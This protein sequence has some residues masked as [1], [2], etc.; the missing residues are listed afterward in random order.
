MDSKTNTKQLF[1]KYKTKGR[2]YWQK[3]QEQTSLKL[4]HAAAFGVP[5]YKLFLKQHKI[6][7]K[8]IKTFADFKKLP[9]VNK[10]NYF[11]IFPF[12]KVLWP[13]DIA[14]KGLSLCATSGST[15]NPVYFCRKDD[16]ALQYSTWIEYFVKLDKPNSKTLFIDAYGL[17]LWL[18]GMFTYDAIN[19]AGERG[20]KVT[21]IPTGI[22]KVE[23]FKSLKNLAPLFDSVVLIGY[24]PF[25]KDVVDE[26]AGQGIDFKKMNL[27]ML[28]GGETFTESFRDYL[29]DKTGIKN[30]YL[31]MGNM[32]GCSEGGIVAWET[33]VCILIKRLSVKNPEIFKKIF[34]NMSTIPTLGQ[35]N[36]RFAAFEEENNELFI[37]AGGATPLIRYQIGDRGNVLELNKVQEIFKSF[38]ISLSKEAKSKG[39]AIENLPLVAIYERN[40]FSVSFYGLQIYPQTIKLALDSKELLNHLTGKFSMAVIQDQNQNQQFEI[41]LELKPGFKG[42]AKLRELTEKIIIKNLYDNNS[43]YRELS[44]NLSIKRTKPHLVFWEYNHEKYFKSGTKQ[45]WM[46]KQAVPVKI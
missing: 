45:K 5:A 2:D 17:G 28:F 8:K 36:P 40:D 37:T 15:G 44:R 12:Q 21:V 46:Q 25:I 32:Y 4:F 29:V 9:A 35:F 18:A 42:T 6:N 38:G 22:N 24:P 19:L 13:K 11:R 27:R 30:P 39:I 14:N 33:P 3:Q 20:C 43:E 23:I 41:N 34:G 1:E 7:P 31:D 16:L 26:A 10:D